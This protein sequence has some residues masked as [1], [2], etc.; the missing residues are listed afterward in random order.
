[1]KITEEAL[2]AGL[3]A[4]DELERRIL[5]D[6]LAMA[7]FEDARVRRLIIHRLK[8]ARE[9]RGMT[10]LDVARPMGVDAKAVEAYERG[11]TDPRLSFHQRYARALGGRVVVELELP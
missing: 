4:Q 11:E 9:A 6:P 1:M 10:V 5:A 2:R 7:A 8:T 3:E